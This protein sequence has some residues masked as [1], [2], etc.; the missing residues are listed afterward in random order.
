M[1]ILFKDDRCMYFISQQNAK[2]T[3]VGIFLNTAYLAYKIR[4]IQFTRTIDQ[5]NGRWFCLLT[6]ESQG[7]K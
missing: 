2:T 1:L 7:T 6:K 3:V 4:M 5:T